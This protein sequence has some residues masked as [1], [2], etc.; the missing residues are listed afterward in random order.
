MYDNGISICGFKWKELT[1][2]ENLTSFNTNITITSLRYSGANIECKAPTAPSY[3]TWQ[4]GDI[5][6]NTDISSTTSHWIY[7]SGVWRVK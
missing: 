2:D 3:G 7:L 6:Y 4:E 1:S 5:V